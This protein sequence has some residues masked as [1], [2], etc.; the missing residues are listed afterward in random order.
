MRAFAS[1]VP[2]A[3]RRTDRPITD[4][5]P[6]VVSAPP[7]RLRF[8][9]FAA[10]AYG[11][12]SLVAPRL[13]AAWK[14][15]GQAAALADYG[16]CMAGPTG[17]GLLR[18]HQL[19]AFERLLRRRLVAAA[20]NE[21][22]FERC[23]PLSRTLTGLPDVETAHRTKAG[24]FAEYGT[25]EKPERTLAALGVSSGGLA[26]LARAAWPFVRGY[27]LLVKPSL[28]AK[29]APHPVSPPAPAVG[30]GLPT[31]R[32]LYRTTRVD[33]SGILLAAGTGANSEALRSTDGG[34]TFRPVSSARVE[35]IAGR[36]PTGSTGR[37]FTLGSSADG[38]ASIASL[39]QGLEP[40][41]TPLGRPNEEVV[42]LAC[43]EQALVAALRT[44]GAK[45]AVLRQC[46]FGGACA[47]LP[48]PAFSG[49]EGGVGFPVDVAR[50]QGT[51]IVALAMGNV[52]RVASTRD[53]GASW[54]PFSVAYDGHEAPTPSGRPPTELLA[55]GRRV[56][57][58]GAPGRV[59]ETYPLLYSDDQGASWHG[60]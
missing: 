4:P 20:P 2:A 6:K 5:A 56:L 53:S 50:V 32:P 59:G 24:S 51:T 58:H 57:L 45:G 35:G 15:H 25:R 13:S 26:E 52:V 29:E 43:D 33:A 60:R 37:A 31:G 55:I 16:V 28:S 41:T 10:L 19:D 54:T 9:L 3:T 23:A 7:I 47:A 46:A 1:A 30:K 22:P 21:A 38:G 18:D 14:L 36:C 11:A 12:W 27:T 40:R 17:P 48:A 39:E 44:D 49:S 34:A 42:A 8:V